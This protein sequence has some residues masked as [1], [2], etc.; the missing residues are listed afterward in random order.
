MST[1]TE[2]LEY[3]EANVEQEDKERFLVKQ[4]WGKPDVDV[5]DF[6]MCAEYLGL[7][8]RWALINY[9]IFI[10]SPSYR[11]LTCNHGC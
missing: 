11:P 2:I 1:L 8:L 10:S 7:D 5:T 4:L 6:G 3:C 9:E